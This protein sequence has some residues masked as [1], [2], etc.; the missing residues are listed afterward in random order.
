MLGVGK[1]FWADSS[2]T[3]PEKTQNINTNTKK[4]AGP[5]QSQNKAKHVLTKSLVLVVMTRPPEI[6]S[7][8]ADW[9]G[10]L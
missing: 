3:K 10:V 7:K 9:L 5:K 8:R 6:N 2:P 4:K 1:R